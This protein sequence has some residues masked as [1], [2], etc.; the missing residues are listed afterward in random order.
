MAKQKDKTAVNE[1]R[2][3]TQIKETLENGKPVRS[4]DFNEEDK[5]S[6]NIAIILTYKSMLYIANVC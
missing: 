5:K 1:V 2:I 6:V 3:L 4:I